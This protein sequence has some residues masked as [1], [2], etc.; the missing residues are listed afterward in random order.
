MHG[1]FAIFLFHV[2]LN[3]FLEVLAH[4]RSLKCFHEGAIFTSPEGTLIPNGLL[5]L[6]SWVP[7]AP[8]GVIASQA[9]I[10]GLGLDAEPVPGAPGFSW[11]AR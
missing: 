1:L 11:I 9:S 2:R 7:A 8:A 4:R 5:D 6:A 3:H 10:E